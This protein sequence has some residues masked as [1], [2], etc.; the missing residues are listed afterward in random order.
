MEL[1][2]LS[3]IIKY[4]KS[5]K[6]KKTLNT[7]STLTQDYSLHDFYILHCLHFVFS[8]RI[9]MRMRTIQFD[10]D[11]HKLTTWTEEVNLAQNR[12]LSTQPSIPQGSVNE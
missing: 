7:Q 4:N 6:Q 8:S 9:S 12:P 1:P 11:F 10:L 2:S 5:R 3:G